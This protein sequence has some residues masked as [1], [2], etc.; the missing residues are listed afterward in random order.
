MER[1]RR[2]AI[3][4]AALALVEAHSATSLRA[5]ADDDKWRPLFNG[6]DFSGWETFLSKPDPAWDVPGLA[7]DEKGNYTENIGANKDPL[8]VFTVETIDGRPAIRI[9]GQGFGVMSTALSFT[10]YHLRLQYKWGEKRW[11][12]K[13][14]AKRDS[15]LLYRCHGEQGAV[16]Q[17]W[18]RSIELQI[19]ETDTGDLYALGTQVTGR[20]RRLQ[21]PPRPVLIY[22]P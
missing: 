22:D 11:G 6:R 5:G 16:D 3:V 18:L 7:K 19:Q 12:K 13:A 14:T 8:K 4:V 20:A 15:G 2:A 10:D 17:N 21:E 1:F 9:S